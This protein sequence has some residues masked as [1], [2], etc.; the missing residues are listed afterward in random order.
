[1]Y[2]IY[3]SGSTGKPKG[4]MIEHRSVV[5]LVCG[6]REL[7]KIPAEGGV[8]QFASMSFDASVWEIFVALANGSALHAYKGRHLGESFQ[9]ALKRVKAA[10]MLTSVVAAIRPLD[11]G[12]DCILVTGGEACSL[13]VARGWSQ[14]H[15]LINAYGPT[16]GTVCGSC[17]EIN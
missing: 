16:E 8:L 13:E 2:V 5:N 4:V 12:E 7:L 11:L 1:A 9:A 10:L 14:K 17:Y 3:T 6:Q 15:R